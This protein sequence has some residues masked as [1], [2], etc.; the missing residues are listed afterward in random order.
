MIEVENKTI[1]TL[2]RPGS[3]SDRVNILYVTAT[4]GVLTVTVSAYLTAHTAGDLRIDVSIN[5]SFGQY[6]ARR[7][8][9]GEQAHELLNMALDLAYSEHCD[10]E[11][12]KMAC[13]NAII[14]H[15]TKDKLE[16]NAAR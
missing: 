12:G 6:R 3:G 2:S 15:V 8:L 14:E 16:I 4:D 11:V 5:N 1:E 7:I 13:S 10:G 9:V